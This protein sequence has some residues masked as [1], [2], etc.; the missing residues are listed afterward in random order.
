MQTFVRLHNIK[1]MKRADIPQ[2]GLDLLYVVIRLLLALW[3]LNFNSLLAITCYMNC[4]HM[5]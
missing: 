3:H 4:V 1:L 5:S 2:K